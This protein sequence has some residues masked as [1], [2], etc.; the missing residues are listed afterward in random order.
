MLLGIL[1]S[2]IAQ[3][4]TVVIKG[5]VKYVNGGPI[6]GAIVVVATVP[7]TNAPYC[8]R[9]DTTKTNPNGYFIDSLTCEVLI[10]KVIVST[11][12]CNGE[13][14]QKTL[15]VPASG[16]VEVAF[17]INCPPVQ[18]RPEFTTQSP[19][20]TSLTRYFNSKES[21]V[22]AGDSIIRHVWTFGDGT[23][24]EGNAIEVKKEYKQ[25]GAY[26]VC[27]KIVT[28]NGC[29]NTL[30]KYI[31][32]AAPPPIVCK[33]LFTWEKIADNT[34][35]GLT[36]RFN[37]KTSVTVPQD[38]IIRRTWIFGD[39][40]TLKGNEI[41]PLHHFKQAGKYE[42]CLVIKTAKGC[43]S[44][45]CQLVVIAPPPVSC[46]PIVRFE[47]LAR[48]NDGFPVRF[49]SSPASSTDY[50][51]YRRWNFGDGS[52]PVDS[53]ENPI[54]VY[55]N[56]GQYMAC[57]WIKTKSGCYDSTCVLIN[58]PPPPP[59][60]QAYFIAEP[61][62]LSVKFNSKPSIF[63]PGDSIVKRL[64]K[65]GDGKILEGNQVD[66][67]HVYEKAGQYE[68]CLTIVTKNGCESKLCK[69]VIVPPGSNTPRC[70]SIFVVA[71]R[72]RN[73]VWFDSKEAKAFIAGDSI[74]QRRWDFGNGRT[75]T[76]NVVAPVTE[77][78]PFGGV[79]N[80]CLT[81]KTAKG[82]ESK[83]CITI[84]ANTSQ[85]PYDS[86]RVWLVKNYPNP[87]Q[88]ILYAVIYSPRD[89]EPVEISVLDVYGIVKSS[90]K[91]MVPK[92]FSIQNIQTGALLPGPYILRVISKDG[93]QSRN[94]YKV[95]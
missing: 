60:C 41:N 84:K 23:A 79:Y 44:K 28:K 30:C 10:K 8:L 39:G 49:F 94:F 67:T 26:Q 82:C 87:V 48:V 68:V 50:I 20:S 25:P 64:W 51:Q 93:V 66:P 83:Y 92:G 24:N 71:K 55:K 4:N 18:C 70:Q 9:Y 72:E 45:L 59:T 61:K 38:S 42:V 62:E 13:L 86:S 47:H 89:N 36:Y 58:I 69:W 34:A 74:V 63:I 85:S 2:C 53:I 37:S 88:K 5:T 77:Y 80:V 46:K 31:Y 1:L 95:P 29:T 75:I 32:I 21:F 90:V 27:L 76:G 56:P 54:H 22:A 35:S 12:G 16:V 11:H 6:P 43:E 65:F 73:K 3:A 7:T 40:D 19:D 78:P 52:N 91:V 57:V 81:I 17:I 15:E 14:L 33:A